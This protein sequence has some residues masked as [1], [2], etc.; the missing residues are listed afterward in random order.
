MCRWCVAAQGPAVIR[1]VRAQW[2]RRNPVRR[3]LPKRIHDQFSQL[4]PARA[5]WAGGTSRRRVKHGSTGPRASTTG[6]TALGSSGHQNSL[7]C[8]KP[9]S[10]CGWTIKADLFKQAAARANKRAQQITTFF[11]H[12]PG[13]T[14]AAAPRP[15]FFQARA[16]HIKASQWHLRSLTE[17][18]A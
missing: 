4:R 10:G 7:A 18:T 9:N 8:R 12:G 2:Q 1:F 14:C 3:Y 5:H 15:P 16:C 17:S 11:Q 13:T 6:R